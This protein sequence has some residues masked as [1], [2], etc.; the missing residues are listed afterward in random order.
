MVN[1]KNANTFT[2]KQGIESLDEIAKNLSKTLTIRESK[3]EQGV[4]ETIKIKDLF[5]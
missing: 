5:K 1:T 2:G 4:E 3:S